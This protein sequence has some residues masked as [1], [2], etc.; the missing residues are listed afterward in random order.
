VER[1]RWRMIYLERIELWR[2]MSSAINSGRNQSLF[3]NNPGRKCPLFAGTTVLR[4]QFVTH[5]QG[6]SD[7]YIRLCCR[8][9]SPAFLTS[10]N[11]RPC[12]RWTRWID[13]GHSSCWACNKSG[14]L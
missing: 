9:L 3:S 4:L 10:S 2:D 7:L 5:T 8:K 14:F 11:E 13:R 12:H 1:V 6:K